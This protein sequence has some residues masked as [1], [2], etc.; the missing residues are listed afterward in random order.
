[1]TPSQFAQKKLSAVCSMESYE[2]L[3]RY[4]DERNPLPYKLKVEDHLKVKTNDR[5]Y[6]SKLMES[7]IK[8]LCKD[9]GADPIKA[10]DRGRQI[11]SKGKTIYIRQAIVKRG[12]ADV[13]CFIFGRMYNIEVKAPNDRMSEEQE[14][15]RER[16][17]RNG[18]VYLIICSIDDVVKWWV[19]NTTHPDK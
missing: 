7:V 2:W 3:Q 19:D 11:K 18:E 17:E 1:M 13:V 5:F 14:T 8:R 9:Y 4:F 6:L 15:E 10:A 12:R 16:A